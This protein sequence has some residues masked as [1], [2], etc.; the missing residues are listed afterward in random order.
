MSK[1]NPPQPKMNW[2]FKK[3]ENSENAHV[4]KMISRLIG[5]VSLLVTFF[6]THDPIYALTAFALGI[7]LTDALF[8]FKG[9][10][11]SKYKTEEAFKKLGTTAKSMNT[12]NDLLLISKAAVFILSLFFENGL[13]Y[14][15]IFSLFVPLLIAKTADY[16]P[17][18]GDRTNST[19][20]FDHHAQ[21]SSQRSHTDMTYGV[22]GYSP[23]SGAY[24]GESS[25]F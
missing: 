10:E 18:I 24:V 3:F 4:L 20:S 17:W 6:T 23:H 5:V 19:S 16:K 15:G 11:E 12:Y 14:Y 7:L 1:Y 21:S 9:M 25:I 2:F 13:F 22:H 8:F